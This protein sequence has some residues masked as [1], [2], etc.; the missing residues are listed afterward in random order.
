MLIPMSC[1]VHRAVD[2][3]LEGMQYLHLVRR[4]DTRGDLIATDR[5]SIVVVP[6][7]LEPE[8]TPG[9]VSVFA[10]KAA[11]RLARKAGS[12][13]AV[14]LARDDSLVL[15]DGQVLPRPRSS[16][17]SRVVLH[18]ADRAPTDDAMTVRFDLDR[19]LGLAKAAGASGTDTTLG[20]PADGHAI[21]V[22]FSDSDAVCWIAGLRVPEP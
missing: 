13:T 15:A 2:P 14:I 12:A 9:L 8:D 17:W 10:V 3:E 7:V 19:L 18:G 21:R 4:D 5:Y 16:M 1:R 20:I 6:V 11:R 22:T